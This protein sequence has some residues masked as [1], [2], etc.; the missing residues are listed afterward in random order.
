MVKRIIA[1]L[2]LLAAFTTS[3]LCAPD[4]IETGKKVVF[5]DWLEQGTL[6]WGLVGSLCLYQSLNGIIDGYHFRRESPR[7]VNSGNYHAYATAQ[8][9]S[10][11]VTG[12]FGYA[13]YRNAERT[14]VQK[15][16]LALGGGLWAWNCMEWSYKG[17]R[18]GNPFDYSE[19]HNEHAI[20]YFGFR[21][22]KLI[23]L[24]IGTG[25]VSGPAVD[26]GRLVLGWLLL[27][28]I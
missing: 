28:G 1:I 5:P 3:A 4:V 10:G 17:Q 24:Y 7:I 20:V 9:A 15:G 21:G 12:W 27:R 2:I 8:R 18:Y 25:K 23:D 22:G 14:W 6:K 11:I 19:K 13:N 16:R 26:I